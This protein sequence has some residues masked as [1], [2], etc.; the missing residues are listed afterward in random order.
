M[1]EYSDLMAQLRHPGMSKVMSDIYHQMNMDDS[2]D[3]EFDRSDSDSR[4]DIDVGGEDEDWR[5]HMS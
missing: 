4:G 1:Y 2:E 3:L 5:P